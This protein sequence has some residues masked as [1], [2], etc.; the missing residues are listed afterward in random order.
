MA[1][2]SSAAQRPHAI[3]PAPTVL[4]GQ[5]EDAGATVNIRTPDGQNRPV[6]YVSDNT[7][8]ATSV[9][10]QFDAY[11]VPGIYNLV[12]PQGPDVLSAN[13][14]RAESNFVKLQSDDLQARLHPLQIVVE[15]E[16]VEQATTNAPFASKELAGMLLLA[17]V[18]LLAVENVCA[19]RL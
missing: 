11:T 3:L 2:L 18:G 7:E 19:N 15:E 10:A 4:Q 1:N 17:V 9:I 6:R 13:A 8:A 14:T 5:P 16:T 12:T